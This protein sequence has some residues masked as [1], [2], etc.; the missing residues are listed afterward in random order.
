M[1][2]LSYN[3]QWHHFKKASLVETRD[4]AYSWHAIIVI[5][6]ALDDI[7][8]SFVSRICFLEFYFS[9]L[10]LSH[11]LIPSK[12]PSLLPPH[13]DTHI[14]SLH[15]PRMRLVLAS[16]VLLRNPSKIVSIKS[17]RSPLPSVSPDPPISWNCVTWLWGHITHPV[18]G[19]LST[20][21]IVLFLSYFLWM[22]VLFDSVTG[23]EEEII[24]GSGGP[25]TDT[26]LKRKD[27]RVGV[28]KK[29]K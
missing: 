5:L 7:V 3:S 16:M 10:F 8:S 1:V 6:H 13:G 18:M 15:I 19:I 20:K 14:S 24:W 28:E 22:W 11:I 27:G 9:Y 25:D 2:T 29:G 17:A 23:L 26:A 12:S 21:E 4:V